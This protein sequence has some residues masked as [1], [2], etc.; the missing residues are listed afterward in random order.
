VISPDAFNDQMQD[1][2]AAAITPQLAADHAITIE[3]SDCVD[4]A[5][6]KISVVKL[7]KV[8]TNSLDS[9]DQENLCAP[10]RKVGRGSWRTAPVLPI[11]VR[12]GFARWSDEVDGD[13]HTVLSCLH[14]VGV[15]RTLLRF[16]TIACGARIR[17]NP[18]WLRS[19]RTGKSVRGSVHVARISDVG[20]PTPYPGSQQ[21]WSS[22]RA[23]AGG[24]G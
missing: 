18:H 16:A 14:L 8:F 23:L 21:R 7:A 5:L 24:G 9:R 20:L 15:F 1:L 3:E 22:G 12:P 13:S 6:P 11:D 2:V 4:G 19:G 17:S 10:A